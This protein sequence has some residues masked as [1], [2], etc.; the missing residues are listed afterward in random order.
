MIAKI[1]MKFPFNKQYI[2]CMYTK[3]PLSARGAEATYLLT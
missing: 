3:P 2:Q 1:F